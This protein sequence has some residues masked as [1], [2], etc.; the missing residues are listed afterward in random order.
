MLR[1]RCKIDFVDF[2][3]KQMD[4]KMKT[5]AKNSLTC[6]SLYQ[7]EALTKILHE[8]NISGVKVT[9]L[10]WCLSPPN[11]LRVR[12]ETRREMREAQKHINASIE[13]GGKKAVIVDD[14]RVHYV[15]SFDALPPSFAEKAKNILSG[16]GMT[17]SL[18]VVYDIPAK[19]TP[20]MFVW[21]AIGGGAVVNLKELQTD[22]NAV[23]KEQA[24]QEGNRHG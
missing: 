12:F 21:P 18:K 6:T 8:N 23:F 13:K 7:C 17:G 14:A 10:K 16:K 9:P 5:S 24:Q 11:G 19:E 15:V 4:T 3:H 1:Y 22:F 2:P 20:N